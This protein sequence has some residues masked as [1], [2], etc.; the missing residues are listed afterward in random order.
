METGGWESR[1]LTQKLQTG[2]T[3]VCSPL[4]FA[5]GLQSNLIS[6]QML[7]DKIFH[8]KT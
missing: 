7:T 4:I 6:C 8:I 2:R 1:A 5:F 3:R